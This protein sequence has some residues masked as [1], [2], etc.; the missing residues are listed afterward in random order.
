MHFTVWKTYHVDC[1]VT[2]TIHK[3]PEAT[4][5]INAISITMYFRNLV[6]LNALIHIYYN[7]P[8]LVASVP[9]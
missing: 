6:A 9:I 1:T 5:V 3:G 7:T 2:A 8:Y 4:E